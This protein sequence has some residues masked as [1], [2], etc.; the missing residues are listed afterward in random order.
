MHSR[1][2]A[3]PVQDT[4]VPSA[5]IVCARGVGLRAER[6]LQEYHWNGIEARH[7]IICVRLRDRS[8]PQQFSTVVSWFQVLS[9]SWCVSELRGSGLLPAVMW[10]SMASTLCILYATCVYHIRISWFEASDEF[11]RAPIH[12]C[13][14]RAND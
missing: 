12:R 11:L 3:K 4:S 14:E 7:R 10:I 2:V 13:N 1:L 8:A 6:H 9:W 5:A